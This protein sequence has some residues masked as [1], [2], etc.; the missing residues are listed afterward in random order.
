METKFP[1]T[2]RDLEKL[3]LPEAG[4]RAVYHD[5]KQPG[6]QLRVTS[7]GV[8]TFSVLAR[9]KGGTPQRSTIGRFPA[10]SIEMARARAREELT[11]FAKGEDP[12]ETRQK[13]REH[14]LTVAEVLEQYVERKRR[15][16]GGPALKPRTVADYRKMVAPGK[17]KADGT[18]SNDGELFTIASKPIRSLTAAHLKKLYESNLEKYGERRTAYSITVLRA[19]LAWKNIVVPGDPFGKG[20]TG[21]D[22]IDLPAYKGK[23]APIPKAYL[24]TWWNAACDAGNGHVGGSKPAADY[25][26]FRLLTGTRGVEVLGDNYGNEPIRVWDVDVVG[27]RIV[28]KNTKNREDH[29][30]LLSKQAL[31]IAK[32]NM[33]GKAPDDLLFPVGDPRKTLQAINK[34]A[35]LEPLAVSG[36]ALRDTF[37]SVG[38]RLVGVYALKKLLNHKVQRNDVT[39]ISY[40][41]VEEDELRDAWQRIADFI[42]AQGEAAKPANIVAMRVS[43]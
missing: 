13:Q 20:V 14:A 10:V 15:K 12:R 22:R 39:A 21:E 7:N 30:L 4:Q 31:E 32:R 38:N 18:Q 29:L 24:G 23:P 3:P 11:K 36:H 41:E 37:A 28:L 8:M 1:F 34:A 25:Y 16:N 2:K 27:A 40:V 42:E 43:A 9:V 26:R 17:S 6:L 5:A 19:L 35:G 33:E